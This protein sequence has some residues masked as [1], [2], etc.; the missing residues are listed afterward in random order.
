MFELERLDQ[1]LQNPVEVTNAGFICLR[2]DG[3]TQQEGPDHKLYFHDSSTRE[4][5]QKSDS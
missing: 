3:E 1:L 5:A 2:E 4:C